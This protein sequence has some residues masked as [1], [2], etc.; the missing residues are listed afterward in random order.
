MN[1]WAGGPRG[2]NKAET[3]IFVSRNNSDHEPGFDRAS[4]RVFRAAPISA[5]MS[6]AES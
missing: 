4:R 3:M 2:C 5:S 1:S 6:S